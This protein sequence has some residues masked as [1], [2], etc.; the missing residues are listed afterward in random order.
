MNKFLNVLLRASVVVI[1]FLLLLTV[2]GPWDTYHVPQ[3]GDG[4]GGTVGVG[5]LPVWLGETLR[6]TSGAYTAEDI[7]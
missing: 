1:G 6:W 3:K 5:E 2:L 4:F 7:H